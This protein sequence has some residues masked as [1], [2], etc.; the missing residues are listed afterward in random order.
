MIWPIYY[1]TSVLKP[2]LTSRVKTWCYSLLSIYISLSFVPKS[3]YFTSPLIQVK[4]NMLA[5]WKLTFQCPDQ[6][7]IIPAEIVRA[8]QTAS[9]CRQA[10]RLHLTQ[11]QWACLRDAFTGISSQ[12]AVVLWGQSEINDRCDPIKGCVIS[13]LNKW[14]IRGEQVIFAACIFPLWKILINPAAQAC[15]F[16][17]HREKETAAAP[18]LLSVAPVKSQP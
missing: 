2:S 5:F 4:W 14:Q 16:M 12:T 6:T 18:C 9:P 3:F 11:P 17:R 7:P 13:K 1:L 10:A 8:G 15:R